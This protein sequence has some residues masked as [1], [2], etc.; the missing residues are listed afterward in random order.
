MNAYV[1]P[2]D[3]CGL[4]PADPADPSPR[5]RA[6]VCPCRPTQLEAAR[7]RAGARRRFETRWVR[8]DWWRAA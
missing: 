3:R 1:F 4:L 2:C 7:L 8:K 5:F 6:G